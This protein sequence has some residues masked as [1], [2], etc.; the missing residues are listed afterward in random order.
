MAAACDCGVSSDAGPDVSAANALCPQRPP[1]KVAVCIVG[2][3]RTFPREQAWR[4]LRRHLVEAYGGRGLAKPAPD[5]FLH[6]KLVDDDAKSQKEWRF[7]PLH[8]PAAAACSAACAFRPTSV[9]LLTNGT[10][11]GPASP[12]ALTRGCFRS[13][14]FAHREHAMRAVSQWSGFAACHA[15][16]LAHEVAHSSGRYDVVV[17]TR[18][19][20][21]WY[22]PVQPH[23]SLTMQAADGRALTVIHR[24]PARW[25]ATLEWL[26]LMPRRHAERILTTAKVFDECRPGEACCGISRSE[27]LLSYAL[28]RAGRYRQQ[29]FGV[30]ILRDARHAH[31]RNAGCAQFDVMG[32]SSMAQCRAIMYGERWEASAPDSAPASSTARRPSTHGAPSGHA[33]RLAPPRPSTASWHSS[34]SSQQQLPPS[35][36]HQLHQGHQGRVEG[37]MGR[38]HHHEQPRSAATHHLPPH[39]RRAHTD[40]SPATPTAATASDAAPS[41]ASASSVGVTTAEASAAVAPHASRAGGAEADGKWRAIATEGADSSHR[42]ASAPHACASSS[43]ATVAAFLAGPVRSLLQPSVHVSMAEH[44]W[45]GFGGERV[46]FARLYDV[47]TLDAPTRRRL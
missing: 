43:N 7:D 31:M 36:R 1:P 20:T 38:D 18:P 46:L 13:G 32:F 30:D 26:L 34:S 21:V 24:G 8:Q 5:V 14:F 47:G 45:G 39:G 42:A 17:L 27:D 41:A 2:G 19:D 44:F 3:A 4:S 11:E 40:T 37:R 16:V 22:T 15:S 6:L 28:S 12:A 35:H 23:C 9:V 25:N 33:P 29:P 10:H